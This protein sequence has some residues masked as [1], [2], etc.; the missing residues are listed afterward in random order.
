MA[1]ISYVQHTKYIKIFRSLLSKA[2]FLVLDTEFPECII[3]MR[4]PSKHIPADIKRHIHIEESKEYK[5]M[6]KGF[7]SLTPL[8]KPFKNFKEGAPVKIIKGTYEGFSGVI[9]KINETNIEV[10]ISVWDRLVKD[11]FEF[12]EVKKIVS[13]L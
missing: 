13:I 12:D 3:V 10:E 11:I 1:Y 4:D 2:G 5:R 6:L 7:D 8:I 9:K